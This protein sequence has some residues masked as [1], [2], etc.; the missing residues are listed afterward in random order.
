MARKTLALSRLLSAVVQKKRLPRDGRGGTKGVSK[1]RPLIILIC[2]GTLCGCE[3]YDRT[4]QTDFV[5]QGQTFK[6][7]APGDTVY[8]IDTDEGEK[9]RMRMLETWLKLNNQ[10]PNGYVIISR[11]PIRRFQYTITGLGGWDV[12]YEGRCN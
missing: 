12:Y 4:V 1:L 5:S 7:K 11:T 3:S 2:L 8:R 6:Y 9:S 10:C